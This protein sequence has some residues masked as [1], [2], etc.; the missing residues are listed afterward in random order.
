MVFF[1]DTF[2]IPLSGVVAVREYG[3]SSAPRARLVSMKTTALLVLALG[4]GFG[5]S[6]CQKEQPVVEATPLATAEV[7][8]DHLAK[9]ELLEGSEK[10]LTI[11]LPRELHVDNAFVQV[12]YASGN[13]S[14]ENVANYFRARVGDGSV[15]S[16]ASATL[17]ENVR[18]AAAPTV[19]LRIRVQPG[20]DGVGSSVEI[21]DITPP[22]SLNLPDEEA[23][24]R[25][26]GLKPNGTLADPKHMQ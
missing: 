20:P 2:A 24:W 5:V 19:Y 22:P 1:I 12:V 11:L 3:S 13:A 8:V 21:R 17:F 15:T 23:R 14:P 7:P 9:G 18:V 6:G 26:A 4:L 16:G 25:S 10:A